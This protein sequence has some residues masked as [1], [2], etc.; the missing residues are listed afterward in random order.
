MVLQ[1]LNNK[2]KLKF[3]LSFHVHL[4]LH[5]H[6]FY[7]RNKCQIIAT[8]IFK[9]KLYILHFMEHQNLHIQRAMFEKTNI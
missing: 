3:L 5:L 7:G 2:T 9:Q 8:N 6:F 1:F 4:V